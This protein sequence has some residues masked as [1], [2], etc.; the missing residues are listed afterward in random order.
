MGEKSL[1]RPL[2]YKN[3][4]ASSI[5]ILNDFGPKKRVQARQ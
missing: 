4:V 2:T 5:D 3:N 1:S